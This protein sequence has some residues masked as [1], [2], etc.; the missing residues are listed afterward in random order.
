MD[1]QV[2]CMSLSPDRTRLAVGLCGRIRWFDYSTFAPVCVLEQTA[3]SQQAFGNF[4][5]IVYV[6]LSQ[7]ASIAALSSHVVLATNEDSFLRLVDART[8]GQARLLREIA[9]GGVA[10]TCGTLFPDNSLY[11][12]GSQVGR[13][14]VWH[15]PTII[16][17]AKSAAGS[18]TPT[19]PL[20]DV[21]FRDDHAVVRSIGVSPLGNWVAVALNSGMV[22]AMRFSRDVPIM[23]VAPSPIASAVASAVTATSPSGRRPADES[24]IVPSDAEGLEG[25]E[26]SLSGGGVA[27]NPSIIRHTTPPGSANNASS[28]A[29]EGLLNASIMSPTAPARPAAGLSPLQQHYQLEEFSAFRAH[30]KYILRCVISPNNQ[31]LATCSADYTINLWQVPSSLSGSVA[32]LSSPGSSTDHDGPPQVLGATAPQS[33]PKSAQSFLSHGAGGDSSTTF[34]L[35]RTLQGHTRWV[36]D[37]TFSPDSANI[38]SA[39]SDTHVRLWSNILDRPKSETFVGHTKPVNCIVLDYE[40]KPKTIES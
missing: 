36:W 8:A 13:L 28:L 1:S 6:P 9:T 19:K 25:G 21:S 24:P 40:R 7:D 15:V 35:A 18:N 17:D 37:I 14:A 23:M 26:S 32:G 31:L 11:I 10:L 22:H 38:I 12:T 30:N 34:A 2:N 27:E 5:S 39:S 20:Q 3:S 33:P 29:T 16:E 4:T